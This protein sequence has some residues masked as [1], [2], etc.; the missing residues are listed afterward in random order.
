MKILAFAGSNSSTSINKELLKFTLRSFQGH[1]V[2][3]LDLNDFEMPIYSIDRE[4]DGI[5]VMAKQ[6][7][8]LIEK[9]DAL[10]IS[11]AEHNGRLSVALRNV[12]DWASRYNRGFLANKPIFLMSTSPGANGAKSVLRDGQEMFPY[13]KGNVVETFS[14]PEFYKN[15]DMETGLLTNAAY[16]SQLDG[17]LKNFKNELMVGQAIMETISI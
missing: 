9:S 4:V 6:F 1:R 7:V 12:I 16:K 8:E 2:E 17:I 11:L 13:F 15:F 10:I 5:P 3:I 14:L